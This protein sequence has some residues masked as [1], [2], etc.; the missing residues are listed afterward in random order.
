MRTV[1]QAVF[2]KKLWLLP[3]PHENTSHLSIAA[4]LFSKVTAPSS[5]LRG[6][7]SF[8]LS[9]V[10]VC[11]MHLSQSPFLSLA[12]VGMMICDFYS[13]KLFYVKRT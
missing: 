6:K 10:V 8:C 1:T 7:G 13:W 9:V 5:L 4:V 2:T 3:A 11:V 12:V